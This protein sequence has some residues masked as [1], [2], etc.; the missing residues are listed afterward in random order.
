M[1][2]KFSQIDKEMDKA[3]NDEWQ[4]EFAYKWVYVN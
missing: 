2:H 3:I 4:I 1:G